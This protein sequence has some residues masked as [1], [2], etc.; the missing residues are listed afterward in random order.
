MVTPVGL[1]AWA[2]AIAA[3]PAP[4]SAR[5]SVGVPLVLVPLIMQRGRPAWASPMLPGLTLAAALPLL[6]AFWLPAGPAAAVATLPWLAIA[7]AGAAAAIRH[8]V[9]LLPHLLHPRN[10]E[11]L[12]RHVALGFLAVGA[13]FLVADRLD[14]QPLGF[15]AP[16]VLLTAAHFGFAGFGLL[17]LACDGARRWPVLRAAVL[18]IV[19]GMPVTALAFILESDLLNAVGALIVSAAAASVGVSLLRRAIRGR[20][21][22]AA[23]AG[24]AL[25]VGPGMGAA[26]ALAL[27]LDVGFIDLDAMVRTHGVLNAAG[28]LLA[29]SITGRVR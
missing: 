15:S 24:G 19:F 4:M 25:V 5:I 14:V 9:P 20:S 28:V 26:W 27:L 13:A 10:A 1:L 23:L 22:V 3:L 17:W 8:G 6:L 11:L 2:V 18:G 21:A 16:I 12:G 7:A 29:A